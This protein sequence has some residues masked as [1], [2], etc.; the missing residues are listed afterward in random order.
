VMKEALSAHFFNASLSITNNIHALM[1][2]C[3]SNKD[4]S[5]KNKQDVTRLLFQATKLIREREM[6]FV[7][8]NDN[9][10]ENL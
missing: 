1:V 10:D 3:I 8:S 6:G 7:T 9:S 4:F 5:S 2:I